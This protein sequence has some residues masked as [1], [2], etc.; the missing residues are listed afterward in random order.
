LSVLTL[1]TLAIFGQKGELNLKKGLAVDGYDVVAYFEGTAK[2]GSKELTSEHEGAT[3]RFSSKENKQ[4]FDKNP[5]SY[6][7]QYG[8]YCAYAVAKDQGKVSIDPETFEVRD[9]KLYLFYNKLFTN[10]L[11]SWLEEG[12]EKLQKLADKKWPEI[13]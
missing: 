13:K 9:G 10:T 1:C 8:G 11:K 3:Y 7:P 6:L 5:E 4:K 2:E 12:P